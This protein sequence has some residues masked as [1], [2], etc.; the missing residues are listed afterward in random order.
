MQNVW[1]L[2]REFELVNLIELRIIVV[3]TNQSFQ[4]KRGWNNPLW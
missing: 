1:I 3:K 4:M 2:L